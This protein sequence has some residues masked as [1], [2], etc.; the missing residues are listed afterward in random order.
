MPVRQRRSDCRGETDEPDQ[1]AERDHP[2][3]SV[4]AHVAAHCWHRAEPEYVR[5]PVALFEHL[6]CVRADEPGAIECDRGGGDSGRD[7][8]AAEHDREEHA[9]RRQ[10]VLAV[11]SEHEVRR[12]DLCATGR[13]G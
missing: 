2:T 9:Q 5:A 13:S 6:V 7:S 3:R 4:A 10:T 12:R 8:G 1:D 11:F